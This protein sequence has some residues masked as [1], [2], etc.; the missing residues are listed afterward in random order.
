GY[1]GNSP[2]TT[3]TSVPTAAERNGDFSALLTT[4]SNGQLYNP[5]SGF[6]N[7]ST[8]LVTRSMIPGNVL[9]NAGLSINPVA[10]NYLKLIPLP[11]YN[12]AS[13][14]ASGENNFFA[15][16]PTTDNYKSHMGRIDINVTHRD[17]FS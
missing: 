5:N 4:T 2:A 8:K 7:P 17:R 10:Q 11:N 16:D 3:I 6:Y 14:T 12:G 1:I 13:T 15:S 9:S